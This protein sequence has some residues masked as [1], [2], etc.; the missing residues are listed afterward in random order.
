MC[1]KQKMLTVQEV[2]AGFDRFHTVFT[3]TASEAS[4]LKVLRFAA[5]QQNPEKFSGH[6]CAEKYGCV[7]LE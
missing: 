7:I 2:P 3:Y 5:R 4:A 6:S 1:L